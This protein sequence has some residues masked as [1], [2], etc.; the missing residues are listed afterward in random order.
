ME[1]R[2]ATYNVESYIVGNDRK[3][4][5]KDVLNY[6]IKLGYNAQLSGKY[7]KN[8]QKNP[9]VSDDIKELFSIFSSGYPDM[10]LEKRGEVSFIE[11]KLDNDSL[12]ES[13]VD[14]LEKLS[15]FA[16]VTVAYFHTPV[17]YTRKEFPSVKK[18]SEEEI[19]ILDQLEQ[20]IR[21]MLLKKNKPL[22]VVA[23]MYEL[24]KEK[25]LT[26]KILP[27]LC[28]DLKLSKD[29]IIWFIN[30]NLKDK[31]DKTGFKKG[32]VSLQEEVLS[33]KEKNKRDRENRK[34][35]I[36]SQK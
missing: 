21:V 14:F 5:E 28:V 2:K 24:Y 10:M 15:G 34:K 9:N 17:V 7:V 1:I 8:I 35:Y 31:E 26:N 23:K 13:Q 6:Y 32:E 16:N 27:C 19:M 33:I 25:I 36:V 18:Y 20:L 29:K 4:K 11:I 22:W 30:N 3:I 12:R